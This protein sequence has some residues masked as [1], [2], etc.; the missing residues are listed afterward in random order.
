MVRLVVLIL[1]MSVASADTTVPRAG[2]VPACEARLRE[3]AD[4]WDRGLD[5]ATLDLFRHWDW[6]VGDDR[7]ELR[8]RNVRTN[9][10]YRIRISS[11][12]VASFHM[13]GRAERLRVAAFVK[14]FRPAVDACVEK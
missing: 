11:R 1:S 9:E 14:R 8:Y 4:E 3:A 5:F 10:D 13:N 6:Q 7:V 12:R 2:W